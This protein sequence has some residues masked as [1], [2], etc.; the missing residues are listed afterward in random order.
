APNTDVSRILTHFEIDPTRVLRDLTRVMD[1]FRTGNERTPSLSL[2]IDE[3]VRAAWV[4]TSIQFGASKVR[5]GVLLLALLDDESLGR[6]ARDSSRELGKI[7]VEVLQANLLTMVAGSAEDEESPS[8]T[9]VDASSAAT[10]PGTM[11]RTPALDQYTIN[12][13][14]R[15]KQGAID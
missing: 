9:P 5:S 4:M 6:L 13:T 7:K 10:R 12:L 15:A 14:E 2:K 3:L 11:T 8:A 1:R